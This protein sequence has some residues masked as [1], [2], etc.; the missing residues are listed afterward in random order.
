[1]KINLI[2]NG[3]KSESFV[4]IVFNIEKFSEETFQI[5]RNSNRDIIVDIFIKE[6]LSLNI[7]KKIGK[8]LL[9]YLKKS[10]EKNYYFN[11]SAI[12]ISEENIK[13][14][15]EI[16]FLESYEF[17]KYKFLEEEIEKNIYIDIKKDEILL[18]IKNLSEMLKISKD[19]INTP[20]NELYPETFAEIVKELGKEYGF[21]VEIFDEDKIL[22]FGMN[23]FYAVGKG[24]KNKSKLIVARYFGDRSNNEIFGVVGKGITYDSGGYSMKSTSSMLNMK[25]DMGGAGISLGVLCRIAKERQKKNVILVIPA[26]ENLVSGESYKP[27]DIIETMSKITVEI[28]NT[29]CEGRMTLADG[30]FYSIDKEKVTKLVTIATLTGGAYNTFG[31]FV[32]PYFTNEESLE[33]VVERASKNAEEKVW[34]M[35]LFQEYEKSIIGN[36]AD[37]KNSSGK[38]GGLISSALFLE[39]FNRIN[40][41]WIHFDIAGNVI[42]SKAMA[43][44]I[45]GKTLY[46]LILI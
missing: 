42:D 12:N 38:I 30:I 17:K 23:A 18:E 35:P 1:M 40:I 9:E 7:V 39:K 11:L 8:N 41:P 13:K 28:E 31:Q 27:G 45:C 32:T 5:Y 20:A 29:D 25:N 46:N 43:T 21:E 6:N 4:E 36:I 2:T 10:S 14:F 34:R 24:S 26:C 33:E 44:G 15:L 16:I 37:L 22:E 19:L 3:K